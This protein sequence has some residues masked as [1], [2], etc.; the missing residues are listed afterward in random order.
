M[1]YPNYKQT[2]SASNFNPNATTVI[3]TH[4]YVGKL[5]IKAQ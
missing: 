3:F 4:G 1:L 2:A 5:V